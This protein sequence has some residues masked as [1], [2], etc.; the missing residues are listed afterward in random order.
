VRLEAT[1]RL[2]PVTAVQAVTRELAG[3]LVRTTAWTAEST[4]GSVYRGIVITGPTI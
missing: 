1:E 4:R 3:R 2:T